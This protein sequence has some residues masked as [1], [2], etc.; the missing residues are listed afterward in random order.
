MEKHTIN[1]SDVKYL[2]VPAGGLGSRLGR[3]TAN[4]PKCLVPVNGATLIEHTL[5]QFAHCTVIVIGDFKADLLRQYLQLYCNQY[6]Y[7][8]VQTDQQGT[9]AG[10]DQAVA[11]IPEDTAFA[12]TW[13]DLLFTKQPQYS[14]D[15]DVA[16]ALTDQFECRWSWSEQG[17]VN[18]ASN[19]QGVAGFFVF[20]DRSRFNQLNTKQSLVRGFLKDQYTTEQIDTFWL[21]DCVE[22]G[23]KEVY[24]KMISTQRFF[25]RVEISEHTVT[26]QCQVEQYSH[27][28]QDEIQWYRTVADKFTQVPTVINENPLTLQRIRGQHAHQINHYRK[29]IM[30]QYCAKLHELHALHSTKINLDDCFEVYVHKPIQ[31]TARAVQWIPFAKDPELSVN[32]KWCKN[33]LYDPAEFYSILTV[34][35]NFCIIHGD[36]TF[37]NTLID[38]NLAVWFIDPRGRFG[39]TAIYGDPRYDW[40]KLYYSAVGNYDNINS[41]KFAVNHPHLYPRLEINSNGYES[42]ADQILDESGISRSTMC[43]LQSTIWFSLVDYVKEDADA[44]MY[45]FYMGVYLWNQQ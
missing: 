38:Q 19:T 22:V 31:R 4:K 2:I 30:N 9:A 33:P 23:Q 10:L 34:P 28:L 11:L 29:T 1:H 32:N 13:S 39:N 44:M 15:K 36:P 8:F 17:L 41:K 5:K 37:S 40:A 45:A 3:Y 43:F 18:T 24:E 7:L 12:V 27:L 35:K 20:R 26:K 16:V 21:T 6:Q 25:N 42:F 14:F